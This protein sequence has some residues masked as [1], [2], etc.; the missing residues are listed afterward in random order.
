MARDGPRPPHPVRGGRAAIVEPFSR[1]LAREG[2]EAVAVA[3]G[4][5]GARA[6]RARGAR[7]RAARPH[8]ARRRRARRLP[9]PAAALGVPI[10]MLTARGTETDRVVGL[11]LGRRRLRGQA[12]QRRR[13]RGPHPGRPAPQ[14]RRTAE[15]PPERSRSASSSRPVGAPRARSTARSSSS[16]A[17]SS[18]C[19]P[20]WPPE[21]A[22]RHPRGPDGRG[23]GREL[24]RLDQDARRARRL[25]A[26][27]ARRRPAPRRAASTRCAASASASRGAEEWRREPARPP[28]AGARL[29]AAAGGRRAG[30]PARA[31]PAR[32]GRRRGAHAGARQADVVAAFAADLLAPAQRARW[33]CSRRRPRR[34]AGASSSS[35]RAGACWPTARGPAGGQR[36]RGRPEIAAALAG[37]RVQSGPPARRWARTCSPPR[38]RCSAAARP[39]GACASPRASPR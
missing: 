9:R 23:V 7:P 35:T 13:G 20:S 22:G 12:L 19:S 39:S 30:G 18:T 5:G 29:R 14:R 10:I 6:L 27:Q 4:R 24:V 2:F 34:C 21:P 11:E 33:R 15:E 32:P 28:R 36:L 3:H 37:R 17:R 1:A 26:P 25:A 31:R 16:H 38:S 8:P